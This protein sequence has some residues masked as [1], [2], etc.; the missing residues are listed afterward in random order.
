MIDQG[1]FF[2]IPSPCQGICQMNSKGYCIGCF[3]NRDERLHWNKFSEF[4][5]QLVVNLCNKRKIK[6]IQVKQQSQQPVVGEDNAA[7]AQFDLFHEVKIDRPSER[8]DQ[9]SLAIKDSKVRD[10]EQLDLF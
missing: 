2:Q 6:V 1:E 10:E 4:Q 7:K 8:T 5:K 3:R 9:L